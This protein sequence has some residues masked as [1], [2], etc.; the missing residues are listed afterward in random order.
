M[1]SIE[2]RD[3]LPGPPSPAFQTVGEMAQRFGMRLQPSVDPLLRIDQLPREIDPRTL[4]SDLA[5]EPE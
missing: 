2:D 5:G 1:A 4:F 3:K